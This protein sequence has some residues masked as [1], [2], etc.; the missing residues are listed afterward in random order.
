VA[1]NRS[2]YGRLGPQLT[3]AVIERL[4]GTPGL[5]IVSQGGD[6]QLSMTIVSVTVGSGS[7]DVISTTSKDTPEA[8]A[9]RTASLT[10]DASLTRPSPD[11]GAPVTKRALLSSS[12][13][14]MI[15]SNP[16]QVET[17]ETEAL[18]WIIEDLSQK[19]GLVMFSEF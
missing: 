3:K 7:W 2:R 10:L 5:N 4:S 12:R 6:A 13:T 14:Y 9:S 11:G 1:Q 16:G 18:D 8:S 15:A 19:I 17:Q